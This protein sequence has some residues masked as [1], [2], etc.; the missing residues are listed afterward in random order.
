MEID[1]LC[2][3]CAGIGIV[4]EDDYGNRIGY[5]KNEFCLGMS[6]HISNLFHLFLKVL[7]G[8]EDLVSPNWKITRLVVDLMLLSLLFR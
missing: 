1:G 6:I 3:I 7:R 4:E 2:V 8:D 5:S